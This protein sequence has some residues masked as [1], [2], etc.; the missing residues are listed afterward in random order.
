M[1]TGILIRK[2][3]FWIGAH[4][5]PYNR[6]WCINPL[7]FFTIWVTLK[8]GKTPG[9]NRAVYLARTIEAKIRK[10]NQMETDT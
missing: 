6:R 1:K 10:Y 7:P 8:G 2:E 3:S 9:E 4:Y 5:S